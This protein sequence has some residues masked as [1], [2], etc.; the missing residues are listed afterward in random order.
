MIGSFAVLGATS[1]ATR[2]LYVL[3]AFGGGITSLLSPCVLPIVPGYLSLMSGL[4]IGELA[5]ARSRALRRIVVNTALF[6]S[7]FTAVF[8]ILGLVT[9]AAGKTLFETQVTLSRVSVG[10]VPLTAG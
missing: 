9:T 2:N 6:V 1:D 5:E 10:P 8:V 3:T 7:G 4:T